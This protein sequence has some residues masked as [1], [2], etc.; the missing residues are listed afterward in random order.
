MLWYGSF[1]GGYNVMKVGRPIGMIY[2]Y[3]KLGIFNTQ[4][5]LMRGFKTA[6]ATKAL[7]FTPPHNHSRLRSKSLRRGCVQMKVLCTKV[8][9]VFQKIVKV[10]GTYLS[11]PP[12]NHSKRSSHTLLKHLCIPREE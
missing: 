3:K 10:H 5:T 11:T 8:I 1:Y 6:T 4:H 9:H 7:P 2:G 12:H